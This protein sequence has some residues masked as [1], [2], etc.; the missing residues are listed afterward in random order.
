MAGRRGKIFVILDNASK[1][2]SKAV[3]EYL[4]KH[5]DEAVL[6]CLPP[7]PPQLNAAEECWRQ[8]KRAILDTYH[9]SIDLFMEAMTKYFKRHRFNLNIYHYLE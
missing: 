9:K 5:K 4:E 3:K 8:F 2:K 1:H 7:W 6:H